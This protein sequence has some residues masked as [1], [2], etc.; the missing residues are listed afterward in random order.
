MSHLQTEPRP[1][2]VPSAKDVRLDMLKLVL[3]S[4]QWAAL[5]STDEIL[6]AADELLKWIE[7]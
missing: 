3:H 4:P 6:K 1:E 5:R 7:Q 2:Y